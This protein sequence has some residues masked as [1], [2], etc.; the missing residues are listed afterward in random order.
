MCGQVRR[1]RT[2]LC[3]GSHPQVTMAPLA[4]AAAGG[5]GMEEDTPAAAGGGQAFKGLAAGGEHAVG[6]QPEM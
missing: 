1:A 6:A 2:P 3:C 4:E 5:E